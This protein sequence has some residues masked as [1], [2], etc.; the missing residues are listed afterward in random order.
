M[1]AFIA[2]GI[3]NMDVMDMFVKLLHF[4]PVSIF[5]L[6]D[7]GYTI[8]MENTNSG[9]RVS[10]AAHLGGGVAGKIVTPRERMKFF[11]KKS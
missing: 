4:L 9:Y 1:A 2:N 3:M 8:Y 5:L 7:V 10:W 6:V 11:S